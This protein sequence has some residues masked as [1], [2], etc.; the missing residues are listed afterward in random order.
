[1]TYPITIEE[2]YLR[3]CEI[4]SQDTKHNPGMYQIGEGFPAQNQDFFAKSLT[5]LLGEL[6]FLQAFLWNEKI[7][8]EFGYRILSAQKMDEKLRGMS[9]KI[10][11]EYMVAKPVPTGELSKSGLELETYIARHGEP[12]S[13]IL[14]LFV[15]EKS[16]EI[17]KE[18]YR[19]FSQFLASFQFALE[20]MTSNY[21]PI[22]SDLTQ[23]FVERIQSSLET[24]DF[25]VVTHFQIQDL[26]PYFS[27]M[28]QQ[29]SFEILKTIQLKL[30]SQLK[31]EDLFLH[32]GP[33]NFFA[34][35]PQC[36]SEVVLKRFE[37]VFLQ[38]E[39]LIVD[40]RMRFLEIRRGEPIREKFLDFS[41][42]LV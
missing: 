41:A 20:D 24:V 10:F 5:L 36:N 11:R 23:H 32:Q 3:S 25:G 1:M 14:V 17:P 13:G 33:K 28:G 35:S 29:K 34:Y 37:E 18:E 22:F 19:R 40:Y 31:K 21:I 4:L 30:Q 39:H 8:F 9:A 7:L 15:K 6:G 12:H 2:S 38:I 27:A 26:N 42:D 16:R